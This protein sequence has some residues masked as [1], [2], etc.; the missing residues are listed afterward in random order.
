LTVFLLAACNLPTRSS[1]P[2]A[3]NALMGTIV[4]ATMRAVTP[5]ASPTLAATPTAEATA[6]P[7]VTPTPAS[8]KVSGKV[9]YHDSNILQLVLYFENSTSKAVLT[10]TVNKPVEKYDI[11]LPAG[12]YKIYGWPTDYS[13]GVLA[14]GRPTITVADGQPQQGVDFCDYSQGAS[15]PYPPGLSAA[16]V[17]GSVAGNIYGYGGS[18]HLTVVAFN[19]TTGYWF[20]VILQ[21]GESAYSISGLPAGTYQVVAYDGS[22]NAGGTAPNIAV[23]AG[24][25]AVADIS[26]WSGS[27]PSNPAP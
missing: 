9:C 11:D 16:S 17:Q 8:V 5:Q 13:I 26:N 20:Y 4:A 22:G 27:F 15:V 23:G 6:T 24:Q 14:S 25:A 18:G 21:K 19:Q 12:T 7:T 1:D 2:A 3:A 10:K